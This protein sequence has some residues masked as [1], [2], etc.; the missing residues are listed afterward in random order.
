MAKAHLAKK[1]DQTAIIICGSSYGNKQA[2]K[3]L[4]N[5]NTNV[6]DAFFHILFH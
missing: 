3:V 5:S 1:Y 4:R 2:C 6:S